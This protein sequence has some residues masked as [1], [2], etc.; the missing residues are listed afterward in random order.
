MAVRRVPQEIWDATIDELADDPDVLRETSLTCRSWHSRSRKHLFYTIHIF[1][2]ASRRRYETIVEASTKLAHICAR[3]QDKLFPLTPAVQ[4][5]RRL[6]LML[7]NESV[8]ENTIWRKNDDRATPQ[9]LLALLQPL[10]N[11]VELGMFECSGRL[12]RSYQF[13]VDAYQFPWNTCYSDVLGKLRKL[14]LDCPKFV[15]ATL[16]SI[17][18]ALPSL[19]ALEIRNCVLAIEDPTSPGLRTIDGSRIVDEHG[20]SEDMD[21]IAPVEELDISESYTSVAT[22]SVIAQILLQNPARALHLRILSIHIRVPA[23]KAKISRNS[24]IND[25]CR[26]CPTSL[27]KFAVHVENLDLHPHPRHES[28]SSATFFPEHGE[29]FQRVILVLCMCTDDT[30][31][32]PDL[33]QNA[34][35]KAVHLTFSGRI[36]RVEGQPHDRP[37]IHFFR[38]I[39]RDLRTARVRYIEIDMHTY[40]CNNHWRE[41]DE[42]LAQWLNFCPPTCKVKFRMPASGIN[43]YGTAPRPTAFELLHNLRANHAVQIVV[44]IPWTPLELGE[45]MVFKDDRWSP[46]WL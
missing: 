13:F 24:P 10:P 46:S 6:N 32:I 26:A 28:T 20:S 21:E 3:R 40:L 8:S 27:E 14:E 12:P 45:R 23:G 17:F 11:L 7:P 29:F 43:S 37:E 31:V 33:S 34:N 2:D 15:P 4:Y 18:T 16:R 19:I 38:Q 36:F 5:V 41:L 44:E 22:W 39:F 30:I 1:N 9:R 35:L 42:G 25:I